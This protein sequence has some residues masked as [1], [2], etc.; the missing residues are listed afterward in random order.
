[1]IKRVRELFMQDILDAIDSIQEYVGQMSE[2]EFYQDR[3]TQDAV[4]RCFEIIGEAA[5]NL[6]ADLRKNHPEIVWRKITGIRN[7][8]IHEYF[9]V[10]IKTVW[11]TI[12]NGLPDLKEKI[13]AIMEKEN[14][15]RQKKL[16]K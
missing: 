14:F 2:I 12:K 1:M 16:L 11:D 3:K 9:G 13:I 6:S 7:I 8:L 15:V 4:L 10:E 5:K